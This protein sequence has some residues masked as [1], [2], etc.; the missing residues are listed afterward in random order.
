[1]RKGKGTGVNGRGGKGE[2]K[3]ASKGGERGKGD[4][5]DILPGGNFEP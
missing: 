3:R 1:M 4:L 5:L 2:G